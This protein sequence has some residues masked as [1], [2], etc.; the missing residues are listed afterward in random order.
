M[1]LVIL[2]A[3]GFIGSHIKNYL[4]SLKLKVTGISSRNINLLNHKEATVKLRNLLSPQTI[5]FFTSVITREKGDNIQTFKKN[6]LMAK[7]LANLLEKQRIK[8][9]VYLSTADVYS[10]TNKTIDEQT[11]INPIT[12]YALSKYVSE[13]IL[14]F[15]CQK[16][17]TPILI[18]RFNGVFG[19][20]QKNIGYGTNYFIK[21]FRYCG[22]VSIWGDGRELR[23]NIYVKDLAKIICQ[24]TFKNATGIFNIAKGQSVSFIQTIKILRKISGCN[25]KILKKRRTA[26]IFNQN[27]NITKL[28]STLNNL[29]FTDFELA[30]KET[31]RS[32]EFLQNN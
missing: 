24:L 20:S 21:S 7:V 1:K 22:Q 8:K 12:F 5:L 11:P 28:K 3:S 4:Q 25:F 26:S 30:L 23:D 14:Q 6:I 31:Y 17:S 15:A 18:I 16:S 19:P 2:G 29:S 10:H 13:K 9:L 32:V 27:F